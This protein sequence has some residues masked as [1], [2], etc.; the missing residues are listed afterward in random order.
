MLSV[1]IV[2]SHLMFG[3]GLENLL[4]QRTDLKVLGQETQ[5]KRAIDQ[6][7]NLKPEVVIIYADESHLRSQATILEILNANPDTRVIALNLQ[8]NNFYV[9]QAA[10]WETTSV[11]DLLEAIKASPDAQ[12]EKHSNAAWISNGWQQRDQSGESDSH[13]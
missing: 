6:I 2:S 7:K 3:Y 13:N 5:I 12:H 11:E 8:N 1:F 10:Q 9:Y 4:R